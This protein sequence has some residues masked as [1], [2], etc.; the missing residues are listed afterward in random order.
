[1]LL[2]KDRESATREANYFDDIHPVTREKVEE[3]KACQ[4]CAQLKLKMNLVG[5]QED[6]RKYRLPTVTPGAW[7]GVI[8]HT[9]TPFPMMYT[10]LKKWTRFKDGSAWILSQSKDIDSVP[11]AEL[12]RIARLGVNIMQVYDDANVI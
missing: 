3:A 7:N 12:R 6:D 9:D 2:W 10:T 5:N 8:I 1:M 4:A 11:T